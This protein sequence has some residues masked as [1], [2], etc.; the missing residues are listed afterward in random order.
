[1]KRRT[2]FYGFL[3]A[4]IA[5][6]A[7]MTDLHAQ[8]AIINGRVLGYDGQPLPKAAINITRLNVMK[9]LGMI[10]AAKDGSFT[11]AS[12]ESG[13]MVLE[14]SGV[15]HQMQPVAVILGDSIRTDLTKQ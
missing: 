3:M 2:R 13:L 1:M 12:D 4:L 5:G 14:I 10:Q 8:K 7:G 15:D 6:I 9:P 11:F